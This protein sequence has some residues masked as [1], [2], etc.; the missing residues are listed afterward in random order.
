MDYTG[1]F[2]YD[3]VCMLVGLETAPEL[4][5]RAARVCRPA[6]PMSGPERVPCE[7]LI[8]AK[9]LAVRSKNL[10]KIESEDALE[11]ERV[12]ELMPHDDRIDAGML[13]YTK[14]DS[15][16]V[17]PGVIMNNLSS[18]SP[19]MRRP[20]PTRPDRSPDT[21]LT[22]EEK[23]EALRV[24]QWGDRTSPFEWGEFVRS[25]KAARGGE[26]CYPR[27]WHPAIIQG[28]LFRENGEPTRS[29]FTGVFDVPRE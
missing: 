23:A 17:A 12:C 22:N 29:G 20:K 2:R 14:R 18:D 8:G 19:P 1:G 28:G 5:G 24:G 10:F 13:L 4:N 25:V 21:P 27:D 15:V 26:G 11:G 9:K 16:V 3:D 6:G 7:L